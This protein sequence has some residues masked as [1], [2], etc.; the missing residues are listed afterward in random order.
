MHYIKKI[1]YLDDKK[2]MTTQNIENYLQKK[3]IVD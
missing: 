1:L 2:E 3:F